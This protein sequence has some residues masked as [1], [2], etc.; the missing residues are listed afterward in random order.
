MTFIVLFISHQYI[1]IY[2]LI[3]PGSEGWWS[4]WGRVSA[5]GCRPQCPLLWCWPV[6]FLC[7]AE[8]AELSPH[9]E[10][11][12]T[13]S[14][15]VLSAGRK[16]NLKKKS[17]QEPEFSP[18]FLPRGPRGVIKDCVHLSDP[19]TNLVHCD[20]PVKKNVYILKLDWCYEIK[21]AILLYIYI[22]ILRKL[23]KSGF[24]Y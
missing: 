9:S 8:T 18:K 11:H 21:T 3:L 5:W 22:Y 4:R 23:M 15:L 6:W 2:N 10:W 16:N 1:S 14:D 24:W 19:R 7:S 20:R 13:S 17:P 12:G